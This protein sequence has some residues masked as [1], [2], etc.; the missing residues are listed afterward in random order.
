[1]RAIGLKTEASPLHEFGEQDLPGAD[2]DAQAIAT[3][4]RRFNNFR[5]QTGRA[6]QGRY[7]ALHVAPGH[8]LAQVA[9][10][11]HLNQC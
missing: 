1:V 3:W 2:F 10:S 11:I 5:G 6:I 4:A 8:A 7:K 9:H